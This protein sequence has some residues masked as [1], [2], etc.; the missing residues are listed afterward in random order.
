MP[1]TLRPA[2]LADAATLGAIEAEVFPD[3]WSI[4]AFRSSIRAPAT[5]VLVAE[6]G[7][8]ILGY[9]VLFVAA[10]EAEVANIAVAPEAR[11]RGV[12][13]RLLDAMLTHAAEAGAHTAYLEVRVSNAVAQRLYERAGFAVVGRRRRY[14]Q[15]P[16]EDALVMRTTLVPPVPAG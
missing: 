5:R 4:E 7:G 16:D 10:D 14:Y 15:H 9:A 12:G 3:P 11:G 13:R 8:E 1:A 6:A 2:R